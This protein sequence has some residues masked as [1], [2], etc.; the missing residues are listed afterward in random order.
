MK[1]SQCQFNVIRIGSGKMDFIMLMIF[2]ENCYA[3]F[4]SKVIC[5]NKRT[6]KN[7][8]VFYAGRTSNQSTIN[9]LV[10][11]RSF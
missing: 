6:K 5:L 8:P 1:R 7:L 11:F 4:I 3:I 2:I 10:I 9:Y